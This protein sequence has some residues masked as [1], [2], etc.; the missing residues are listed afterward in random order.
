MSRTDETFDVRV[1][2]QTVVPTGDTL[3]VSADG[4]ILGP[5]D[6]RARYGPLGF[7]FD[8]RVPV[9]GNAYLGY[10][11]AAE[12]PNQRTS[13]GVQHR[14]AD[15]FDALQ[16]LLDNAEPGAGAESPRQLHLVAAENVDHEA[17]AE[18]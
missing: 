5:R 4:E 17:A 15:T 7:S 13:R 3:S 10:Y 9:L 12:V 2:W 11:V 8:L 18:P 14:E 1:D 6:A 16:D